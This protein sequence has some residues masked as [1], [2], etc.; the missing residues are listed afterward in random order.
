MISPQSC[1]ATI[2]LMLT[3]PVSMSTETSAICTPPTPLEFRSPGPG[4][5]PVRR[6][7]KAPSIAQACFQLTIVFPPA[8][9]PPLALRTF[10][11]DSEGWGD[12][13]EQQH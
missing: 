12:L 5:A 11:F 10:G 2:L 13:C 8:I 4:L 3:T 6:H 7:G 9:M 1:T